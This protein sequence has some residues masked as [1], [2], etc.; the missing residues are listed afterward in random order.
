MV[1]MHIHGLVLYLMRVADIYTGEWHGVLK[2]N[3]PGDSP[4]FTFLYA[5]WIWLECFNINELVC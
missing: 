5:A 3:Q 1:P 2:G 4:D